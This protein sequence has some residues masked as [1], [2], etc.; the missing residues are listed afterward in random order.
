MHSKQITE[1]ETATHR[2][3]CEDRKRERDEW[4]ARNGLTMT[5]FSRVVQF[6]RILIEMDRAA[7]AKAKAAVGSAS[8][9]GL[10]QGSRG[11]PD[12]AADDGSHACSTQ[13]GASSLQTKSSPIPSTPRS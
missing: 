12:V 13:R 5:D 9:D 7:K 2:Q 10:Q 3:E 8:P 1:T 11:A 6:F 4:L